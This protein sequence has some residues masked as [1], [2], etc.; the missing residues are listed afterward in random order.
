MH[1]NRPE[2]SER[3]DSTRGETTW[4]FVALALGSTAILAGI[5]ALIIF[6]MS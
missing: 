1:R 4:G 5:L 2:S 6:V 3:H